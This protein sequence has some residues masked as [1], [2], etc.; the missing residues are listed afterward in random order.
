MGGTEGVLAI[1][2]AVAALFALAYATLA[3]TQPGQRRA[4]AFTISY[5]V[6]L[7]SPAV[8]FL[9][10]RASHP[11]LLEWLAYGSFLGAIFGVAA[12]FSYYH[13]RRIPVAPILVLLWLGV[14]IRAVTWSLPR[15]T[16][17]YGMAYQAPFVAAAVAA[18]RSVLDA[19]RRDR[20]HLT[21]AGLFG[22]IAV[23]FLTKPFLQA[24]LGSGPSIRDYI[25]S[26]YALVSQAST[27]VLLLLANLLLLAIVVRKMR[28]DRRQAAETDAA[29][30]LLNLRGFERRAPAILARA[31][32]AGRGA[33]VI[34][35]D[36]DHSTDPRGA[37]AGDPAVDAFAAA[38][39][40]V[41]PSGALLTRTDRG[42]F[43]ALLEGAGLRDAKIVAEAVRVEL[44]RALPAAEARIT[45]SSGV[46]EQQ[47]SDSLPALLGR[48]R[49]A[50]QAAKRGGGNRVCV[51]ETGGDAARPPRAA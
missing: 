42:A 48:A 46:A 10:P 12:A 51:A 1:N 15:D 16:L 9:V 44:V 41:A 25:D 35:F 38:V 13:G 28:A 27:G 11:E 40:Q 32:R 47:A 30:G 22:L 45:V 49:D 19:P 7:V 31:A 3:L 29:T 39:R 23:N 33:T 50:V 2:I 18:I 21:L 24:G 6:G 26:R 8:E 34:A 36:L 17:L 43:A 20:L 4:F 37:A 14:S 5:L